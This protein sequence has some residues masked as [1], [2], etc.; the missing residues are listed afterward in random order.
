MTHLANLIIFKVC[1]TVPS[2]SSVTTCNVSN[3]RSVIYNRVFGMSEAQLCN[4]SHP[5][6]RTFITYLLTY[7]WS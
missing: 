2:L 3:N 4:T 1:H 5:L 6:E 7:V